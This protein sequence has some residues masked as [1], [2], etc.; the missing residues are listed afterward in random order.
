MRCFSLSGRSL[1]MSRAHGVIQHTKSRVE[2][3]Q[4]HLVALLGSRDRHQPLIAVVLWLIDL[5]HTSTQMSNF[6]D[7]GASLANDRTDHIIRNENLLCEWLSGKRTTH[8]LSG[9]TMRPRLWLLRLLL[10][11]L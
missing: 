9:L 4:C 7:L 11:L 6:V 5:D 3:V 10:W 2:H 8:R 1:A